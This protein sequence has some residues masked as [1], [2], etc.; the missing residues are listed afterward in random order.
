[1]IAVVE[2]DILPVVVEAQGQHQ[3]SPTTVL[4]LIERMNKL[5]AEV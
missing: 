5:A 3:W 1:L 2:V 4:E